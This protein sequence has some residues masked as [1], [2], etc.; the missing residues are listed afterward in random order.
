MHKSDVAQSS[1]FRF[2]KSHGELEFCDV[3]KKLFL[4]G[5]WSVLFGNKRWKAKFAVIIGLGDKQLQCSS[6][7]FFLCNRVTHLINPV[8]A[9]YLY[10]CTN[11]FPVD[12]ITII[13]RVSDVTTVTIAMIWFIVMQLHNWAINSLNMFINDRLSD[14]IWLLRCLSHLLNDDNDEYS[15]D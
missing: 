2:K 8:R 10:H 14:L 4:S 3:I 11:Q 13:R 1:E 12:L 7:F 15:F 9:V 5:C 6:P